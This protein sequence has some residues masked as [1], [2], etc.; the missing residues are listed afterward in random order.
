MNSCRMTKVLGLI[1]ILLFFSTSA[2]SGEDAF[3]GWRVYARSNDSRKLVSWMNCSLRSFLANKE[4][5]QKPDF[6][7]PSYYGKFGVFVTLVKKGKVRGCFGAFNHQSDQLDDVLKDYL[8]GALKRDSRYEPLDAAEIDDVKIVI[9]IAGRRHQIDDLDSID[10]ANYGVAATSDNNETD[11]I[12]PSEI[13]SIDALKRR[14]K[15][16]EI[17]QIFVFRAVTIK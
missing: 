8:H 5:P 7:A 14:L 6:A 13:I 11:V 15:G 16:K 4:C 12:V 10:V 1:C 3:T 2:G 9:T 17:N